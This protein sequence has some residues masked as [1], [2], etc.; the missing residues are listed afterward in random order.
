MSQYR[1][2]PPQFSTSFS[3]DLKSPNFN[4][5]LGWLFETLLALGTW[6]FLIRVYSGRQRDPCSAGHE[7]GHP[8]PS[9]R[10][11][12]APEV[13]PPQVAVAEGDDRIVPMYG[14][15][16]HGAGSRPP[17]PGRPCRPSHAIGF[18]DPTVTVCPDG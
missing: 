5:D 2:G 15:V 12:G 4:S 7:P 9:P 8:Y 18:A 1:S 3:I 14:V 11:R 6:A 13:V 17:R 10:S 16:Q